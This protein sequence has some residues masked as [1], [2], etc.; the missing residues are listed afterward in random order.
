MRIK[1]VPDA[2]TVLLSELID[3]PVYEYLGCLKESKW[4]S[5]TAI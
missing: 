5:S 3:E 1:A 2:D 4:R